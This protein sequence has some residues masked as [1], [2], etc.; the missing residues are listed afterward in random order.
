LDLSLGIDDD[1]LADPITFC[2]AV[3]D[4]L[5]TCGGSISS[6]DESGGLPGV[7]PNCSNLSLIYPLE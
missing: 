7:G 6:L 2:P 1:D 5:P 4:R 3:D